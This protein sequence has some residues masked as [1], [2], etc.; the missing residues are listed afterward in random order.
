[1]QL[2]PFVAQFGSVF[3][4]SSWVAEGVFEQAGDESLDISAL[5]AEQLFQRFETVFMTAPRDRQMAT[6]RAHPT[7]A[8]A[9]DEREQLTVDSASEQS[10]AGL[11]LC[12]AAE[13][14]EFN[15]LNTKYSETFGF[16]FVI[17][18][19]GLD[20]QEI[21]NNFRA[22]VQHDSGQEFET[23][24]KQVCRIARFRIEALLND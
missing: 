20:R 22:R 21:L 3:E 24:L 2:S 14:A 19:K 13:F 6:L 4:H 10:A 11:D 16:P 18:V 8:C 1:M 5:T 23:A 17:A 7:L 9:L 12:T 15:R